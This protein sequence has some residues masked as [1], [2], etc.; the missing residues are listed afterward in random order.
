MLATVNG[1]GGYR[2]SA[3]TALH[4]NVR[5]ETASPGPVPAGTTP[6]TPGPGTPTASPAPRP[7]RTTPASQ[8]TATPSSGRESAISRPSN[9]PGN[10]RPDHSGFARSAEAIPDR[11]ARTDRSA[12]GFFAQRRVLVQDQLLQV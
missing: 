6:A 5:G 4:G 3:R 9:A 7:A 8:G 11:N 2:G 1:Y 10:R 12:A